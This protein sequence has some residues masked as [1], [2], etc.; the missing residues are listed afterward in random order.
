MGRLLLV[1]FIS[2]D[3]FAVAPAWGGMLWPLIVGASNEAGGSLSGLNVKSDEA[4]DGGHEDGGAY[5]CGFSPCC[6]GQL[7]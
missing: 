5:A 2:L 7:N 4:C 6:W 1:G 3:L